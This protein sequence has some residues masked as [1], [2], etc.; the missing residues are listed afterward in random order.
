MPVIGPRPMVMLMFT[1]TWNITI[2]PM[3][4]TT[5]DST[6]L[7]ALPAIC[8]SR[9]IHTTK[10]TTTRVAPRNPISSPRALKMKSVCCSGMKRSRV[11]C[12]CIS[13]VPN[14]P[15]EPMPTVLCSRW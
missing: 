14:Q 3:P 5:S 10:P 7:R 8:S 12:P 1:T 9:Q 2:A 15:P 13:P 6:S 11:R 4:T